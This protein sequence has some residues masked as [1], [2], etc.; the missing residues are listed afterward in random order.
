MVPFFYVISTTGIAL[1]ALLVW[2]LFSSRLIRAYPYFT[3][4]VLYDLSRALI[5]V[6][7]AHFS[8]HSFD[9]FYWTTE[10]VE[11]CAL[12][13]I[14][15]E[16]ARS[17]FPAKSALLRL[18]WKTLLVA[19][20]IALPFGVFLC[21]SQALLIHYAYHLVPPI[22]EQYTSLAQGILLLVIAAVAVYYRVAF[23]RNM[24]GLIFGSGLFLFLNSTTYA[25]AQ[26]V[27]GLF[28]DWQ[29]IPAVMYIALTSIW[30]WGFWAYAPSPQSSR[31]TYD[32]ERSKEYWNHLWTAA[33]SAARRGSN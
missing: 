32:Q 10:V 3:T 8:W 27:H 33:T 9:G 4:F 6:V 25:A 5:N 12:F 28:R 26:F 7:L 1:E 2:R 18:A 29:L 31:L 15:W 14:V 23:G 21:W 24:R 20:A 17:L 11:D 22:F 16:V 30:L 13:L 19:G